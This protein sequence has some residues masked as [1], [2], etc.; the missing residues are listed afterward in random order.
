MVAATKRMRSDCRFCF[1]IERDTGLEK[2][3]RLSAE[4]RGLKPEDKLSSM[5]KGGSRERRA[6]YNGQSH[7]IV[8]L[9]TARFIPGNMPDLRCQIIGRLGRVVPGILHVPVLPHFQ[10]FE[11]VGISL[12]Q[13]TH[14][15][16]RN[17]PDSELIDRLCAFYD[18]FNT[19]ILI[20]LFPVFRPSLCAHH[21]RAP[22]PPASPRPSEGSNPLP[23]KR[24]NVRRGFPSRSHGLDP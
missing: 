23:S 15:L 10:V 7:Q 2:K 14:A 13:N 16:W 17:V 1:S 3:P 21:V 5:N 20:D 18:K 24:F 12:Y 8:I 6:S 4:R 19:K 22:S 11:Q 9:E